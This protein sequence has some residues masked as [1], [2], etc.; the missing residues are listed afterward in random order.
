MVGVFAFRCPHQKKLCVFWWVC[1]ASHQWTSA[2]LC[3][4]GCYWYAQGIQ[5]TLRTGSRSDEAQ[6]YERWYV[7][8]L[9]PLPNTHKNFV[10]G[11]WWI[12]TLFQATG[13][14]NF[15]TSFLSPEWNSTDFCPDFSTH[16]SRHCTL[17]SEAQKALR[18]REVM[19]IIL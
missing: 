18:I 10:M 1:N 14:R 2:V 17:L 6:P 4:Y 15:R 19:S 3:I 16:S 11:S 8:L 13:T 9:Q 7:Y 5:H 12:C